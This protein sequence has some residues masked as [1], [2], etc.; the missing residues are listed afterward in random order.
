MALYQCDNCRSSYTFAQ[1][2]TTP[3]YCSAKCQNE[4]ELRLSQKSFKQLQAE[5]RRNQIPPKKRRMPEP[6]EPTPTRVEYAQVHIRSCE[7]CGIEKYN[8]LPIKFRLF[9]IDGNPNNLSR[10]NLM[11]LCPNCYS[12]REES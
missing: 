5:Q 10:D 1:E 3:G 9:R 2:S 6:E 8:D 12:Q 11:V 7:A 4:D